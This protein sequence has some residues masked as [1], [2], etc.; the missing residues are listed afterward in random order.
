MVILAGILKASGYEE[1]GWQ[2]GP[3]LCS[4]RGKA[5]WWWQS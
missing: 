4:Q 5:N 2:D 1:K 3:Q